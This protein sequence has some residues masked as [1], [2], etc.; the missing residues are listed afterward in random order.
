[1]SKFIIES[2]TDWKKVPRTTESQISN[3]NDWPT[4]RHDAARSGMT[5]TAVPAALKSAWRTNI[6][7]KL[8]SPVIAGDKLFVASVD[9]HTIHALDA[10]SGEKLWHYT[11]G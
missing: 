9:A 6:V 11:A 5:S 2:Q 3:H 4:Y 8:T 10:V 7:G 1:M